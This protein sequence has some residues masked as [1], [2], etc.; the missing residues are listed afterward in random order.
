MEILSGYKKIILAMDNDDA[1][2]KAQNAILRQIKNVN[3]YK[4]TFKAKDLNEAFVLKEKIGVAV[5]PL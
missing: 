1:G 5:C 2:N 4:L 3:I